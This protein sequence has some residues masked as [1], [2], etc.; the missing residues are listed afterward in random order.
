M[1]QI[2]NNALRITT[3][4][5]DRSWTGVAAAWANLNGTG[6]IAL[7]DSFNVASMVDGGVGIYTFNYSSNMNAAD[8]YSNPAVIN[9]T[10]NDTD[11]SVFSY[12]TSS[13]QITN[14]RSAANFDGDSGVVVFG[15]L[16]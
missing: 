15:D 10:G 8:Y 4:S 16:A 13:V 1:T 6:T 5:A 14:R 7:R 12:S 2:K 9:S 11:S 3:E